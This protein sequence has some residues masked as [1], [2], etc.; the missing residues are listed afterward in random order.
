MCQQVDGT[1]RQRVDIEAV[2]EPGEP[3]RQD[4]VRILG[5]LI[6][7]EDCDKGADLDGPEDQ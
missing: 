6:L 7:G 3:V 5:Q 1:K 2:G 4:I